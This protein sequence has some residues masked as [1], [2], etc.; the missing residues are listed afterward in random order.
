METMKLLAVISFL[1]LAKGDTLKGPST[2]KYGDKVY[3]QVK[4]AISV[5]VFKRTSDKSQPKRIDEILLNGTATEFSATSDKEVNLTSIEV[6]FKWDQVDFK[7]KKDKTIKL[8]SLSAKLTFTRKLKEYSLTGAE[9]VSATIGDTTLTN[10]QLQAHSDYGSM[11]APVGS[12]F[13]CSNLGMLK[14]TKAT[15]NRTDTGKFAVGL[16]FPKVKL[17][18]FDVKQSPGPCTECAFGIP[19]G[20]WMGL[21]V[22]LIFA[23]VCYYGFSMLAS[24][25]TNDRWDDPKGMPIQVPQHD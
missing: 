3:L 1:A 18:V 8:T 10:N 2:F 22:T 17:Q 25:T 5:E 24:I 15:L 12:S 16:S 21:I 13:C 23:L 20:F 19:I 11:S 9:V 7:G 6:N 4:P 14:P